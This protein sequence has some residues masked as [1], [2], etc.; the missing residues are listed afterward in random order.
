[1][2]NHIDNMKLTPVIDWQLFDSLG[3]QVRA[4]MFHP[5]RGLDGQDVWEVDF[6]GFFE[7]QGGPRIQKYSSLSVASFVMSVWLD[8]VKARGFQEPDNRTYPAW[9]ADSLSIG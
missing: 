2:Q 4:Q 1:M 6:S 3:N 7:I 9:A 5:G 8:S